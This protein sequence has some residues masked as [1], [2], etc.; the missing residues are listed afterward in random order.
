MLGGVSTGFLPCIVQE[1]L[2]L[3]ERLGSISR[4][5]LEAEMKVIL[6]GKA[7]KCQSGSL[8]H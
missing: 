4:G 6:V 8:C 5:Q 7:M 3:T 1:E 2:Y